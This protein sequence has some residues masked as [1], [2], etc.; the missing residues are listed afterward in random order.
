MGNKYMEV[1]ILSEMKTMKYRVRYTD[2]TWW[3]VVSQSNDEW[4]EYTLFQH[5]VSDPVLPSDPM[6]DKVI[7]VIK[8]LEGI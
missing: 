4:C 5:G 2:G 1:E 6:Y 8:A 3:S 7:D